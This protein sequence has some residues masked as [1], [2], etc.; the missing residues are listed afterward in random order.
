V[1]RGRGRDGRRRAGE[2]Q[3][4]AG[5]HGQHPAQRREVEARAGR[6]GRVRDPGDPPR[7]PQVADVAG[8]HD[9]EHGQADDQEAGGRDAHP[10]P[11]QRPEHEAPGAQEQEGRAVAVE[12]GAGGEPPSSAP[13]DDEHVAERRGDEGDPGHEGETQE[14]GAQGGGS[15]GGGGGGHGG[16]PCQISRPAG[17]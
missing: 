13:V 11:G 7:G 8:D 6:R 17:G 12:P 2:Q 5:Q 1:A 4:A 16:S 15:G 9:E 10:A 3:P 14:A